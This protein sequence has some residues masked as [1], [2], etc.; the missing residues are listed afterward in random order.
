MVQHHYSAYRRSH[1]HNIV[2]NASQYINKPYSSLF[3]INVFTNWPVTWRIQYMQIF[4]FN[5]FHPFSTWQKC[6]HASIIWITRPPHSSSEEFVG[7]MG[8]LEDK[9]GNIITILSLALS[10]PYLCCLSSFS[11][12]SS[13]RDFL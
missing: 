12:R 3:N 8:L 6:L 5:L 10:V 11:R 4:Y 7:P 2:T 13:F 1:H 9:Y